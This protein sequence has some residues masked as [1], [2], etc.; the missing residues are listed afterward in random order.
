MFRT[1]TGKDVPWIISTAVLGGTLMGTFI[2]IDNYYYRRRKETQGKDI[3]DYYNN[4]RTDM[5][6]FVFVS[7]VSLL[8][9]LSNVYPVLGYSF[10]GFTG[11]IWTNFLLSRKITKSLGYT[12][13]E[14][15]IKA[16]TKEQKE[17][18]Q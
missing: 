18:K 11:I 3:I 6:R 12:T 2:D 7:G 9:G 15:E 4:Y 14:D 13:L 17:E 10:M 8:C 5:S 1:I 16:E